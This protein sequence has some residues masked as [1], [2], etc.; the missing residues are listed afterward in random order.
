AAAV[1]Y[2]PVR[3]QRV[4]ARCE[5][6]ETAH[7]ERD[8]RGEDRRDDAAGTLVE[9]EALGDARRVVA[10]GRLLGLERL[11]HAAASLLRPPVIAMP[12]SSSVTLGSN[13]PAI[14]P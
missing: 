14:R 6:D 1:P 7:D 11:G 5:H 4:V 13:S 3:L 12:S 9:G 2:R 10:P 8:Q